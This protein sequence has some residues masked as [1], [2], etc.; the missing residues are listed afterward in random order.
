M[1]QDG[2]NA[3]KKSTRPRHAIPKALV[4]AVAAIVVALIADGPVLLSHGGGLAAFTT[5]SQRTASSDSS[6]PAPAPSSTG[7]A[8]MSE[9]PC[10]P[11]T[12]EFLGS[13]AFEQIAQDA[14]VEYM[15]RCKSTDPSIMITITVNKVN[16]AAVNNPDSA[17]GVS[18]ACDAAKPSSPTATQIIGMYD[19]MYDGL[20]SRCPRLK[21][22]AIGALVFSVVANKQL[23]TEK[24]NIIT[25]GSISTPSLRDIFIKHDLQGFLAVGRQ[26]GSGTRKAFFMDVLGPA[27]QVP[28]KGN[29]PVPTPSSLTSCT[30][31]STKDLLNF[32][33][34]TQNAIGYAESFLLNNSDY[35]NVSPLSINGAAPMQESIPKPYNFWVVEHLYADMVLTPLASDF[36][37]W[38]PYYIHKY[39]PRDGFIVCADASKGLGKDC[40]PAVQPSQRS[41]S[42]QLA[43]PAVDTL[44]IA[45]CFVL[46]IVILALLVAIC[47]RSCR[48]IMR[49]RKNRI[50]PSDTR[51]TPQ[52]PVTYTLIKEPSYDVLLAEEKHTIDNSQSAASTTRV[53]TLTRE[54]ATTY[55]VD[56]EE[57][58]TVRV[59]AVLGTQVLNLRAEAERLLKN[60]YTVSSEERL[61]RTEEVTLNIAPYTKSEII[62][63][64]K[65]TRQKGVVRVS[66][67][68]F[69]EQTIPYEV[70]LGVAFDQRQVDTHHS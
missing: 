6:P 61:T 35:P 69:E 37:G 53:I 57:D 43:R 23:F 54:L 56:V 36:L 9:P 11:G 40:G 52:A 29:C 2:S 58:R 33:N 45:L 21:S 68:G 3:D 17:W 25:N 49:R 63:S 67:E 39:V 38:L 8:S 26:A 10:A 44:R 19:G 1:A 34:E 24:T 18:Q 7:S 27:S 20:S 65:E 31:D 28:D 66:G 13:S 42:S 15:R 62:F 64:W 41:T 70:G 50:H 4:G 12:L 48:W 51:S 32:V 22:H 46:G 55:V 60:T 47:W 59:N 30:E 14:A 5:S 16:G